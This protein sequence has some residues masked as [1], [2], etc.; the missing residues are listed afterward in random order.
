MNHAQTDVGVSFFRG[1]PQRTDGVLLKSVLQ[2]NPKKGAHLQ[3]TNTTQK[4][5]AA[6]PQ[7]Q[8]HPQPPMVDCRGFRRQGT[9]PG[10]GI[11]ALFRARRRGGGLAEGF[12]GGEVKGAGGS[13]S[14]EVCGF[15]RKPPQEGAPNSRNR[16]GPCFA[17]WFEGQEMRIGMSPRET[18]PDLF[19]LGPVH[20]P[21]PDS[22]ISCQS[23]QASGGS[24]ARPGL[25]RRRWWKQ[26]RQ[27]L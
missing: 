19:S 20:S 2:T 21:N 9:A 14:F 10:S 8:T 7:K 25:F 18:I 26:W 22:V 16:G 4:F 3:K 12:G 1:P 17:G 23:H 11:Q 24:F 27:V 13:A 15:R 6:T 5:G